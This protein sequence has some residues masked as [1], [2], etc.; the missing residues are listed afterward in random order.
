LRYV[1]IGRDH[2]E[3]PTD[4]DESV[5][6]LAI[7]I[8]GWV[9]GFIHFFFWTAKGSLFRPADY[10]MLWKSV[11]GFGV[12]VSAIGLAFLLAWVAETWGGGWS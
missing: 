5:A 3:A 7:S 2:H 10:G 12:F 9:H 8:V 4:E 11:P 1:K 6:C